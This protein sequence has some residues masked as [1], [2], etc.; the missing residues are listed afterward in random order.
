MQEICI[1]VY[2][3]SCEA[4]IKRDF[5]KP[6]KWFQSVG[7]DTW[8]TRLISTHRARPLR[9]YLGK[10]GWKKQNASMSK[11]VE[12]GDGT[13][14]QSATRDHENA[15]Y[16]QMLELLSNKAFEKTTAK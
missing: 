8:P 14:V 3:V 1:Y 5:C 12:M 6:A 10:E 2:P 13:S 4:V 15:L 9:I 7:K 11:G 16:N